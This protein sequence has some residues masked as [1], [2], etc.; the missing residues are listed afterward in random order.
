MGTAYAVH[1]CEQECPGMGN[2]SL[3]AASALV[4]HRKSVDRRR[5]LD[6]N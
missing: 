3:K 6:E 1:T 2:T 4:L 5:W